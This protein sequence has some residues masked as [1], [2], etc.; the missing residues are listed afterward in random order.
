MG[1]S[2]GLIVIIVLLSV[3]GIPWLFIAA[4]GTPPGQFLVGMVVCVC[5]APFIVCGACVRYLFL[6]S[7]DLPEPPNKV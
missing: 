5:A 7:D 3:F 4:I 2:T 6:K 1:C